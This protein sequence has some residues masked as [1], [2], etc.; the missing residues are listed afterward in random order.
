VL[1]RWAPVIVA[2]VALAAALATLTPGQGGPG[3]ACDELYHVVVGRKLV[4]ALGRDGLEFFAPEQIAQHFNWPEDGPP[5]QAPLGHW[6]L[7][8]AQVLFGPADTLSIAAA[9]FAPAVAFGLLVLI[10]GVYARW[11]HGWLAGI[12]AG[13]SVALI[14]RVFAHAHFA[15]LDMLVTLPLVAA[16]MA[17]IVAARRDQWWCFAAAGVVWGLA[18]LVKL[19]GVL[20]APPI[21]AWLIWHRRRGALVPLVAW[22]AAGVATLYTGWPWLWLA[23]WGNLWRYLLSGAQRSSIHVFYLGQVW[24]DT[25]APW[26]YPLVMFLV[27]LP[28]GLLVLGV[29]GVFSRWHPRSLARRQCHPPEGCSRSEQPQPKGRG[30]SSTGEGLLLATLVWLLA[31]FSLPGVPIYDGVRLILLAFPLWAVFVG[32]GTRWLHDRACW[33]A[34]PSKIRLALLAVVVVG[35]GMGLW[36]YG[37]CWTS[38][39]SAAVGGLPGAVRL[40][41]EVTYWGDSVLPPMLRETAR[42]APGETVLF[43][44]SLAP[45]QLAGVQMAE[46]L[47]V[48]ANTRL[49]GLDPDRGELPPNCRYALVYRRRADLSEVSG[50]LES[51]EVVAEHAI[52]DVWLTR[53]I[54]L[55]RKPTPRPDHRGR[56]QFQ[57]VNGTSP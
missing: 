38:H 47:L 13:V 40:G 5:V 39:Y 56:L 12:V 23:P 49:E 50:V 34:V 26:H 21:I 43:E 1:G 15:A 25:A 18:M 36:L 41:F 35:Q 11:A 42:R 20:I 45:F 27:T 51:G 9:R 28:L 33:R 53:L 17:M 54:E 3:I 8:V 55:D 44:P 52:Q 7:G 46:P 22:A 57:G 29:I 32:I 31:V 16:L 4:D 19:H 48:R 6:A 2:A 24:D 14:P 37:P 10:V 30:Q